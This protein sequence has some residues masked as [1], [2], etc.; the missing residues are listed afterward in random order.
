MA[1]TNGIID[2][3]AA[4]INGTYN[5]IYTVPTGKAAKIDALLVSNLHATFDFQA[6]V[7]ATIADTDYDWIS[8]V[9][10]SGSSWEPG[11]RMPLILECKQ[12]LLAG[13][14]IKARIAAISQPGWVNTSLDAAI[15]ISLVEFTA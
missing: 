3:K 12:T 13:D 14:L 7:T 10:I 9:R 15:C 5:T 8:G 11:G 4:K 1:L 6:W 2:R